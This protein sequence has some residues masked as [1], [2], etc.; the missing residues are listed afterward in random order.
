MQM[1]AVFIAATLSSPVSANAGGLMAW[2]I[3]VPGA[4]QP[5]RSNVA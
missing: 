1:S 3:V 4:G 2:N 5:L